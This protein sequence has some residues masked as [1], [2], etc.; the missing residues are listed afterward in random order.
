MFRVP[1]LH[2]KSCSLS[3][4]STPLRTLVYTLPG[5]EH[6]NARYQN[7]RLHSRMYTEVPTKHVCAVG[8]KVVRHMAVYHLQAFKEAA[9]R[10]LVQST[11]QFSCKHTCMRK[12]I[13]QVPAES[14]PGAPAH[15][16]PAQYVF[17]GGHVE[18]AACLLVRGEHRTAGNLGRCA[19]VPAS[20][21]PYQL[22]RPTTLSSPYPRFTRP[23][24]SRST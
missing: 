10:A 18:Q 13:G 1:S 2:T 24:R 12:F 15:E 3:L 4:N 8:R 23:P 19:L 6:F 16:R 9:D 7:R 5:V 14:Q 20:S 11:W 22:L 17:I 21:A